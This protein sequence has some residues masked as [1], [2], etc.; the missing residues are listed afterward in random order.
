MTELRNPF[1]LKSIVES[2]CDMN[3]DADLIKKS[4]EIKGDKSIFFND[5]FGET[6]WFTYA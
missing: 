1:V 4:K 5:F 6:G 3:Y 2:I